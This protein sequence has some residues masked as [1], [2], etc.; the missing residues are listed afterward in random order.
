MIDTH[1]PELRVYLA[2]LRTLEHDKLHSFPFPSV[3]D[4]VAFLG[5]NV[6]VLVAR[7]EQQYREKGNIYVYAVCMCTL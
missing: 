6:R 5:D 4:A 2:T 7:D 1:I 3:I